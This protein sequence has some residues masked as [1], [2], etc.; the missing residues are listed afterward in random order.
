MDFGQLLFDLVGA[1]LAAIVRLG[2]FSGRVVYAR[3]GMTP[4]VEIMLLTGLGVW[5]LIGAIASWVFL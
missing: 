2:T 3:L 5:A 1:I 4:P